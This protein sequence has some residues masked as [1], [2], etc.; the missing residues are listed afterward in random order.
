MRQGDPNGPREEERSGH[1]WDLW[2]LGSADIGEVVAEEI[3]ELGA[4]HVALVHR[5]RQVRVRV[6]HHLRVGVSFVQA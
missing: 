4:L 3:G 1:L 2:G 6:S 5:L